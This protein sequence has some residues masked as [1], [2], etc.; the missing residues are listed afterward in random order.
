VQP[1]HDTNSKNWRRYAPAG[2]EPDSYKATDGP[3]HWTSGKP[4]HKII[5]DP[6]EEDK[7][8]FGG[9]VG[10]EPFSLNN[11]PALFSLEVD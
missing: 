1:P 5:P 7:I 3:G 9:L 4:A 2:K 11:F 10:A 6:K 8:R